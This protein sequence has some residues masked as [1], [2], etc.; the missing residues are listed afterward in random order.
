MFSADYHIHTGFS[1]DSDAPMEAMLLSAINKGM[2]EIAFTDHVDYDSKYYPEPDYD[3]YMP[4][5]NELK[6]KY[7]DDINIVFGVEIGLENK[8]ADKI[9]ALTAKYPFD[10]IIGSSHCVLTKDLYF[11]QKEYFG[12]RTKKEAYTTYFDELY[13]NIQT[14]HDFC[15]YGHID[16][17]SRYGMYEDNSLNYS[18]YKDITDKCLIALID[19]GKGIEINTSGFRYG[20]NGTYPSM[21]I[22]KR[23]RELGGEIITA[24]SDS[25]RPEDT[26]DHIDYAYDMM[27]AAGF[28]YVSVFR[29]RKPEF[30]KL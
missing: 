7:K 4:V 18:E 26:A 3:S 2:N 23:Y 19:K 17:V 9:N 16:F 11:D 12:G 13:K 25:H 5:F 15:V 21:D 14:C 24:G 29:N 20:I 30:I 8:W 22:L 1:I 6:E 27:R 10:F 28:R